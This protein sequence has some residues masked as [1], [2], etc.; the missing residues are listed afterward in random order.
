[1]IY[2]QKVLNLKTYKELKNYC[3]A[4]IAKYPELQEKYEKEIILARRFYNNDMNLYDYLNENKNKISTRYVIPFLLNMT[5]KVTNE[6]W[7]YKFAKTSI[8]NSTLDIDLDFDPTGKEKIQQYLINRFG[9]DRV[10]HVGTFSRLGPSSAAKDLLRIY[11]IDFKES[12]D[13]TTYLRHDFSWEEN[14]ANLKNK[15]PRQYTFY[16]KHKN[17]LD[18]TPFFVNKIRGISMHAGGMVILDRPINER[19]PVERVSGSLVT[20][21]PE[22][23]QEQILD[24]IGIVKFDILAISILDVIRSTITMLKGKKLFLVE[25]NGI[26]KIVEEGYLK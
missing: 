7:E 15:F 10:L 21:F 13:F 1:M 25:E 16:E 19:V 20:A 12:N 24:E 2:Y 23:A 5:S 4:E 18:L 14:L 8:T 17:I 22:S 3:D 6:Q 9:D 11:K 26:N